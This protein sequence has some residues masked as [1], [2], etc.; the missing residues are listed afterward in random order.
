MLTDNGGQFTSDLMK[1]VS[2][3]LSIRQMT[4]T[5]YHAQCNGLV[6]RF[7]GTLK[8]MLRKMCEEKPKYWDRYIN[9]LLFA[10]REAVQESTGFSPFELLF[11]RTVRGPLAILR[12]LWTGEVDEPDTKTTYQYVL[13]LKD[14]LEATCQLAQ[15][16]LS[17]S[18]EKYRRQYNRKANNRKF[19]VGDEVLLLLPSN[20]NKLLMHWQGPFKVVQRV[21]YLDY[22]INMDGKVKTFHANLLKKFLRRD[23]D[24]ENDVACVSVVDDGTMEEDDEE[25]NQPTSRNILLH[26]P[27]FT[28][29]ESLQDVQIN[30]KLDESQQQVINSL[31]EEYQEGLTDMPGLTN[32]GEHDI[33][34]LNKEPIKSKPY[35]LPHALR[36]EV[37]KEVQKM[38]ELRVVEPSSSPYASPIVMVKKKD[39][40]IRFCC[41][42]RKL[43]QVTV[44]DAEPIPD[45]EE[46][47]AKLARDKYFTKIDLAKGYWQVPLT[48]NAKE[49]TA[50][51]TSDGLFQFSTMPLG[52]VN[53]PASFSRIMRDLLRGL[54][55]VDNFID[56]ILIHTATFEEHIVILREVL[57][58]LNKANL[59]A[60]PTKCFIGY[61]SIEFLGHC[62]GQG[63][64]RPVQDKVNAVQ[65]APRPKT[66][67]QLR[68]F[69]GLVGYYR[70]FIPN[71]AAIAAPLTD[72]TKKGEPTVVTWGDAEEMAFKKKKLEK[73][74]I[75]HLPDLVSGLFCCR[76]ETERNFLSRTPAG[77]FFHGNSGTQSWNES[78]WQ[79]SGEP[80]N[81][82]P[83][84]SVSISNWKLITN[85]SNVSRN[86]KWQTQGSYDGRLLY[87]HIDSP[88]PLSREART[89]VQIISRR[90]ELRL[91]V[92]FLVIEF[93]FSSNFNRRKPLHISPLTC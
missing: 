4:T 21:G 17:K 66:K 2:R 72:R 51:V 90:L 92:F 15:E 18:A 7:N 58:R 44:T 29:T 93:S 33:K 84:C 52:L 89:L 61:R 34:L 26:L 41:D 57:E 6:E 11:G 63:E 5:P 46:I 38:I 12:E 68:S 80:I 45:Q 31:L 55:N 50:F 81:L 59:T 14:R 76:R 30:P 10:Y 82:K 35:P 24:D 20:R 22:K 78:V 16:N 53:A 43:N 83:T 42:Y 47:F 60:R 40:S 62:V 25:D 75:L 23:N 67:K 28:P 39:G 65:N 19:E 27:T 71:F 64:L 79:S 36:G 56:D 49:L 8:A 70:R 77:S 91:I 87:N 3:L 9:P 69:L 73:E 88:S 85:H 13:D 74:P 1:E 48:D 86:R 54:S 32:L 37:T